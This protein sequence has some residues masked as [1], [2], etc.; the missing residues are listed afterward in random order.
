MSGGT[1]RTFPKGILKISS[2]QNQ[3]ITD[4]ISE[5][6]S[7]T[8]SPNLSQENQEI[9]QNYRNQNM[10]CPGFTVDNYIENTDEI[11]AIEIKSP[12]PNSGEMKGEKQ[13]ILYAKAGLKNKY[14]NKTIHYLIGFPF[15]PFSDPS[16]ET[17]SDKDNFISSNVEFSKFF[18]VDEILLGEEYW[19][20]LFPNSNTMEEILVIIR[21]IATEDFLDKFRFINSPL[22]YV[23]DPNNYTEILERY[24][25]NKEIEIL[26]IYNQVS[27]SDIVTNQEKKRLK[28]KIKRKFSGKVFRISNDACK[29][30]NERYESIKTLY[31]QYQ[32][33]V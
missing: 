12:R 14:P 5:L 2:A 16:E 27:N 11:V 9:Y 30:N 10:D 29:Y 33:L 7:G 3:K 32:S 20:K 19:N 26:E 21:N 8:R 4:I 22:N 25:L 24:S 6:K 28:T 18:S 23:S 17:E 31:E 13:K 1:K 15:D